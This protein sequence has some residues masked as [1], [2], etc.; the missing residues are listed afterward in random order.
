MLRHFGAQP[1]S[2]HSLAGLLGWPRERLVV[3]RYSGTWQAT[4]EPA[5]AANPSCTQTP[6][7]PRLH[8]ERN[9]AVRRRGERARPAAYLS[10]T[11]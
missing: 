5:G 1:S 3:G 2:D 7:A 8:R 11:R 4:C 10:Q 9:C 6:T